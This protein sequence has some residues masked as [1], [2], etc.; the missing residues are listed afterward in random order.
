M[1]NPMYCSVSPLNYFVL[2]LTCSFHVGISQKQHGS[3]FQGEETPLV[4]P[5][6]AVFLGFEGFCG[7]G[8]FLF[9]FKLLHIS[10]NPLRYEDF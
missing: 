10:M 3:N 4:L 8:I 6:F 2:S 9:V 5:I 7:L 1:G